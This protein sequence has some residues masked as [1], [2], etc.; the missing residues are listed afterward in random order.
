MATENIRSA[1]M[2]CPVGVLWK[3]GSCG[4]EGHDLIM[5]IMY[6]YL[7]I[8]ALLQTDICYLGAS[9]KSKFI[10]HAYRK[11][12]HPYGFIVE[13]SV[14]THALTSTPVLFMMTVK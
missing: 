3:A 14:S 2:R 13:K 9:S 12:H 7:P 1:K 5:M 11:I 10:R 4:G 6:I 8:L